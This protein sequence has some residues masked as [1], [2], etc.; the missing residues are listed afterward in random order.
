M[1]RCATALLSDVD[2]AETA[3][4]LL[5]GK[6]GYGSEPFRIHITKNM[7]MRMMRMKV[8]CFFWG[9]ELTTKKQRC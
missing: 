6:T 5:E 2:P 3:A 7:M 9:R 4:E 1:C 8:M